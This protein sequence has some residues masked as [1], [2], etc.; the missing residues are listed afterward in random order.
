M[1]LYVA[2]AAEGSSSDLLT[3]DHR[4]VFDDVVGT[5]EMTVDPY[6][7]TDPMVGYILPVTTRYE[8]PETRDPSLDHTD[9]AVALLLD[10]EVLDR[11]DIRTR[12]GEI[13][14]FTFTEVLPRCCLGGTAGHGRCGSG[15]ACTAAPGRSG[16]VLARAPASLTRTCRAR[17]SRCG[18]AAACT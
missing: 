2:G 13:Q 14:S 10:G 11:Q 15:H 16:R 7:I 1:D 4:M 18:A 5:L 6:L 9:E 17:L 3:S 8:F 12:R